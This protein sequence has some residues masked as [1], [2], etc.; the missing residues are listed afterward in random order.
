MLLILALGIPVG[1]ELAK[2]AQTF[3]S[4][5]ANNKQ[6]V[7]TGPN[8][9][10]AN[11]KYY[12][13]A[14]D[15]QM[16]ITSP[17]DGAT[18]YN[19]NFSPNLAVLD[20]L[21]PTVQAGHRKQIEIG[22]GNFCES[23]GVTLV[24]ENS[25]GDHEY[26]VDNCSNYGMTCDGAEACYTDSEK[27][28]VGKGWL[29]S[30]EKT[31]AWCDV[32]SASGVF[33][34][35]KNC[36]APPPPVC[37]PTCNRNDQVCIGQTYDNGCGGSCQGTKDCSG[38]TTCIPGALK[39]GTRE[40]FGNQ[41][42]EVDIF[43]G[44]TPATCTT[45]VKG[46][47][48]GCMY[49]KDTC[50]WTGDTQVPNSPTPSQGSTP[51]PAAGNKCCNNASDDDC[52]N[53]RAV[54]PKNLRT[55][56]DACVSSGK[57]GIKLQFMR[58]LANG[59]DCTED[60]Q[61]VSGSQCLKMGQSDGTCQ[62]G[63]STPP[64]SGSTPPP[65]GSTPPPG[66]Y[67]HFK[68]SENRSDLADSTNK[69]FELVSKVYA[70]S[71]LCGSCNEDEDC[72]IPSDVQTGRT[73]GYCCTNDAC[74]ATKNKCTNRS[75]TANV[76]CNDAGGSPVTPSSP[77]TSVPPASSTSPV[78]G[79][80]GVPSDAIPYTSAG[81]VHDFTLSTGYGVKKVYIQFYGASLAPSAIKSYDIEYLA[82]APVVS[83]ISCNL[84]ITNSGIIFKLNGS[85]FGATKGKVKANAK[86]ITAN[87]ILSWDDNQ[88][89]GR[90]E[91][92]D[93]TS[94]NQTDETYNVDVIRSDGTTMGAN[95]QT[96]TVNLSQLSVGAKPFCKG[97]LGIKTENV[98]IT[99]VEATAGAKAVKE[100]VTISEDG[101]IRDLKTKL[102]KCSRYF[103]SIKAPG[104]VR[105]VSEFVAQEGTTI[106][107][108]V[109]DGNVNPMILPI[110]DIFP[111]PNGDGS[112]GSPDRSELFRQWGSASSNKSGDFNRDGKVNSY[113]AACQR[114]D[115]GQRD[116]PEPTSTTTSA[117]ISCSQ[118]SE[119]GYGY[120]CQN[121]INGKGVC[122]Y[123][124]TVCN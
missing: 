8:V 7:F 35:F 68:V 94:T 16:E 9:K 86:E 51:A 53:N 78:T 103:I 121:I 64:P 56:H 21:I 10:V 91:N 97:D 12:A 112:I 76:T 93:R 31:G 48:K 88:I 73:K 41:W 66:T 114:Y 100:K 17:S 72:F 42:C 65:S 20:K 120:S 22:A 58:N 36:G 43:N 24:Y 107:G 116:D 67:T 6:I 34:I 33:P 111:N 99:L 57:G 45:E 52:V 124:P 29:W 95:L 115:I 74:G 83:G 63:G 61:C 105:R 118:N 11:N 75:Y 28:F 108:K 47:P 123:D 23:D 87:K 32:Y 84:D 50:G 37:T 106:I 109:S 27:S 49:V 60:E 69:K 4:Q 77:G 1:T 59:S 70:L 46:Q 15:I 13:T 85:N 117:Q 113:D 110:G 102:N 62:P 55:E 81:M 90:L 2:N 119:C 14:A 82:P 89:T 71:G 79:G 26:E 19:L 3:R 25:N 104:S 122:T 39:R 54:T 101:T 44:N 38:G 92:A 40:C 98:Q 18:T 80:S 30:T 5:A 96:C